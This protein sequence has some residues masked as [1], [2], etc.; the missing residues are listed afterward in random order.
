[1]TDS[2][3]H[4]KWYLLPV[5]EQ[6]KFKFLTMHANEGKTLTLGGIR[7]LNMNTC[8]SVTIFCCQ[9]IFQCWK[10]VHFFDVEF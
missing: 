8:V 7:P 4:S 1:M 3:M 10:I 9:N 2:L 5:A 6:M